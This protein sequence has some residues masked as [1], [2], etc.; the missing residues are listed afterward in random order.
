MIIDNLQFNRIIV[1]ESLPEKERRTGKDLYNDVL[2]LRQHQLENQFEACYYFIHSHEDFCHTLQLIKSVVDS[3]S[4][5]PV[6]HFEMHGSDK[7]LQLASGHMVSWSELNYFFREINTKTHNSLLITFASCYG[8]SIISNMGLHK[9]GPF[10]SVIGSNEE[11]FPEEI[12]ISFSGFY[13]T[14][15][16][17]KSFDNAIKS[18]NLT[19]DGKIKFKFINAEAI[20][21]EAIKQVEKNHFLNEER[22][23]EIEEK[24]IKNVM[25]NLPDR[26]EDKRE[27]AK[28]IVQYWFQRRSIIFND[29]LKDFSHQPVLP[30]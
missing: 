14:L 24:S 16:V 7:G 18:L 27:V 6:I 29:I 1:I 25:L 12:L 26:Y 10:C 3:V 5:A 19:Y 17:E 8:L 11:I 21:Q 9:K 4:I 23:K 22:L 28:E 15:L 20:V 13:D 30:E 2:H